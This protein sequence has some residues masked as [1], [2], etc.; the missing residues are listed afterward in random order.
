MGKGIFHALLSIFL[1]LAAIFTGN[2]QIT[3]FL[4]PAVEPGM[5]SRINDGALLFRI[6]VFIDGILLLVYTYYQNKNNIKVNAEKYPPLWT[7]KNNQ[8]AIWNEFSYYWQTIG[9]ILTAAFI[10]RIIS[11][12][13]D[14]WIDEVFTVVNYVRLPIGQIVTDYSTDNQHIFFS[15]LSHI[16]TTIFGEH[17]WSIRLPS[18]LFGVASIWATMKLASLVYGKRIAIYA[19]LLMT[20][21]YHHI[22]FSQNARGYAILLFGATLS[23]YY[24][25]RALQYQKWRYWVGY[26]TILAFSIWTH[27]TAVFIALA[28]AIVI[29][30]LLVNDGNIRVRIWKPLSGFLLTAWITIHLHALILPQMIDFYMQPGA[31]GGLQKTVMQNPMWLLQETLRN[32]GIDPSFQ[33]VAIA[34]IL[35]LLIPVG[36]WL[37]KQDRVFTAISTLPGVLLFATM[38]YLGRN[39]WPRMFFFEMSAIIILMV[40]SLLTLGIF[41]RTKLLKSAPKHY[42]ELP[43]AILVILFMMKLPAL[44]QYPKQDFT[45]ARDYVKNNMHRNDKVVVLAHAGYVFTNYYAKEWKTANSIADLRKYQS[46]EGCTWILYSLPQHIKNAMPEISHAIKKD[47]K[48]QKIFHGTLGGGDIFIHRSKCVDKSIPDK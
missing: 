47:Y 12:N 40:I 37:F 3:H 13:S 10:L 8:P 41:T 42:A 7:P 4:A 29:F 28:H 46:Q 16:S 43:L 18:L 20:I 1:I 34:G 23:T 32:L 30:I 26:A 11:L 9:I 24:L 35:T 17:P 44:Y 5:F 36:Y 25:L 21:S 6:I 33:W 31:G 48:L 39:L 2:E 45:G 27:I 14:L 15:V 19:G 38:F 22:W